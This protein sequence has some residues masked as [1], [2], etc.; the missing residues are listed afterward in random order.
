MADA[1]RIFVCPSSINHLNHPRYARYAH[2][3]TTKWARAHTHLFI[4]LFFH[5]SSHS[6]LYLFNFYGLYR[7]LSGVSVTLPVAIVLLIYSVLFFCR[8]FFIHFVIAFGNVP[9]LVIGTISPSPLLFFLRYYLHCWH[10]VR[11]LVTLFA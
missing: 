3:K 8:L 7:T 1:H 9:A 6:F 10:F 4:F 11:C 5:S 2:L